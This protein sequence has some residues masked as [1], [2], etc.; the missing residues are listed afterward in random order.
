MRS[1][2]VLMAIILGLGS[3]HTMEQPD[4][5]GNGDRQPQ[6]QLL[7]VSVVHW[8]GDDRDPLRTLRAGHLVRQYT[9]LI[10]NPPAEETL[11]DKAVQK[12]CQTKA[13]RKCCQLHYSIPSYDP[14]IRGICLTAVFCRVLYDFYYKY[15]R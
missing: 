4:Q 15:W 10:P 1:I 9:F 5:A 12:C 7:E 13:V 8:N 2:F 14:Y 6:Y 11:T 3:S